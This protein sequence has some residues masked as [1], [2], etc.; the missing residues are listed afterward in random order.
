MLRL[1]LNTLYVLSEE[2]RDKDLI[3]ATFKLRALKIL[4]Y[5]PQIQKCNICGKTENF[6]YFSINNNGYICQEC[7]KNDISGITMSEGTRIAITYI[8][9]THDKRIHLFELEKDLIKELNLIVKV[10]F[11]TKLEKEY[12]LNKLF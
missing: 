7:K 4:G 5:M 10:Y 12:I 8:L 3:I 1:A 11:N 6:K 9:K 2:E